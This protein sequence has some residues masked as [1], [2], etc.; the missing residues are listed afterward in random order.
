MYFNELV[1]KPV[2]FDPKA[3]ARRISKLSRSNNSSNENI[4]RIILDVYSCYE[5]AG[6]WGDLSPIQRVM[7]ESRWTDLLLE[8]LSFGNRRVM[9]SLHY[10]LIEQTPEEDE[11]ANAV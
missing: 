8:L 1:N 5:M 3:K 10:Q 6:Y 7:L 2:H 9:H 11:E 4:D